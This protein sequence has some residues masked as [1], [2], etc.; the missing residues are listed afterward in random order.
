MLLV[1]GLAADCDIRRRVALA[2]ESGRQISFRLVAGALV[3][4]PPP[5][6]RVEHVDE[7]MQVALALI[8]SRLPPGAPRFGFRVR[9]AGW[10]GRLATAE[11]RRP[12]AQP[13]GLPAR[14]RVPPSVLPPFN[15]LARRRGAAAAA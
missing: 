8:N 13:A 2:S 14:Q 11:Q 10:R 4:A 7:D 1:G 3:P 15:W 5:H 12:L 6:C 9:A